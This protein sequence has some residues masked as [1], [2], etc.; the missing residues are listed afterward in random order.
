VVIYISI[1][2][3]ILYIEKYLNLKI[4]TKK[5][6]PYLINIKFEELNYQDFCEATELIKKKDHLNSEGLK[7]I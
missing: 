3:K 1:R 6:F 2:I 7:K 5:W 4:F